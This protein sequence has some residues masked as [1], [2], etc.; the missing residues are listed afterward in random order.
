MSLV[1]KS[2]K[3]EIHVRVTG[4]PRVV[5]QYGTI[6]PYGLTIEERRGKVRV[7]VTGPVSHQGL[8]GDEERGGKWRT[9]YFN[10]VGYTKYPEMPDWMSALVVRLTNGHDS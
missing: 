5:T 10:G 2:V 6:H 8:R 1:I 3:T 4:A 7:K 9:T